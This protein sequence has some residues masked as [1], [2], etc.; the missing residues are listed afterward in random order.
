MW[1][2]SLDLNRKAGLGGG[3]RAG[4]GGAGLESR[5]TVTP[6]GKVGMGYITDQFVITICDKTYKIVI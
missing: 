3:R 6:T 4:G 1:R 2:S 5:A